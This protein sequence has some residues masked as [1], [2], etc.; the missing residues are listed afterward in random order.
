MGDELNLRLPVLRAVDSILAT[1]QAAFSQD[2]FV[3]NSNLLRYLPDN[4]KES[5]VWICD[6]DQRPEE[7]GG[8][9]M[10]ILVSRGEYSPQDL[11]LLNDAGTFTQSRSQSDLAFIP[12]YVQCEAGNKTQSEVLASICYHVIK[13]FRKELM[14]EFDIHHIRLLG[15]TPPVKQQDVPGDPWISTV[16]VQV[17][18]QELSVMVDIANHLNTT[19]IL[20]QASKTMRERV[21]ALDS[22]PQ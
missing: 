13:Y 5:K 19:E 15:I 3:D 16:N 4:P 11:H 17:Q 20:N 21:L 12:V 10:I 7:R 9:R 14:A 22:T 18:I 8:N 6:A 1:M 2:K